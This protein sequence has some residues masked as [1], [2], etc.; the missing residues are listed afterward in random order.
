MEQLMKIAYVILLMI[1]LM[2]FWPLVVFLIAALI[3]FIAYSS[4]KT[5]KMMKE[6]HYDSNVQPKK[7]S[8]IIE[9]E[10]TE[11]EIKHE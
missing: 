6:V 11:K 9:A 7:Q 2:T 1:A 5:K 8:D 10:Y 4:W 3:L